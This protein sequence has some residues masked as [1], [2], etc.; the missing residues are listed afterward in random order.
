MPS[1]GSVMSVNRPEA[2]APGVTSRAEFSVTITEPVCVDCVEVTDGELAAPHPV[3]SAAVQHNASGRRVRIPLTIGGGGGCGPGDS[4]ARH[5]RND[6]APTP[7]A[8]RGPRR[9]RAGWAPF[10]RWWR[11]PPARRRRRRDSS[12]SFPGVARDGRLAVATGWLTVRA[13]RARS[14]SGRARAPSGACARRRSV[15]RGRV[16]AQARAGSARC[17]RRRDR[18]RPR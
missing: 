8:P 13:D 10:P 11:R 2:L 14:F 17:S 7:L 12:G 9:T 16:S 3:A 18:G 5:R 1:R 6:R 4:P 15:R